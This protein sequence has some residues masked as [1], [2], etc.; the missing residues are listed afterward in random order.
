MNSPRA[1]AV[2]VA[3]SRVVPGWGVGRCLQS[4]PTPS[5]V[6]RCRRIGCSALCIAT[7]MPPDGDRLGRLAYV[8]SGVSWKPIAAA[9]RFSALSIL[10]STLAWYS[11]IDCVTY[12]WPYLSIL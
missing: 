12:S 6:S 9:F 5:V 11:S 8:G 4:P 10:A 2:S 7:G 1:F 3:C